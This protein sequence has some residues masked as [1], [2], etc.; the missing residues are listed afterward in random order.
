MFSYLQAGTSQ[1]HFTTV[2]STIVSTRGWYL[3]KILCK[4]LQGKKTVQ[5]K[6][7]K[8]QEEN[9][10]EFFC[11]HWFQWKHLAYRWALTL[12]WRSTWLGLF[13]DLAQGGTRE[14][15]PFK[16]MSNRLESAK[17]QQQSFQVKVTNADLWVEA[18][19]F[20]TP[21]NI[22]IF[23]LCATNFLKPGNFT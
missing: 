13:S 18:V 14:N 15:P 12:Y 4:G 1:G 3:P 20:L 10:W 17:F 5:F 21:C 2:K 19:L 7:K 23:K 8:K 9:L 22:Y 11:F 16:K 6:K